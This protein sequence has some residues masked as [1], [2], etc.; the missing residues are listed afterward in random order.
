LVGTKIMEHNPPWGTRKIKI[1]YVAN[2]DAFVKFLLLPQLKFLVKEGYNVHAIFSNNKWADDIEKEG[3][4][5]KIIRIKRKIT[6]LYDLITLYRLWSYFKKEKF[7]MV[8]TN[9]PKPGLL[10][11]LAARMAGVPIIMNTVHGLYFQNNSSYLKRRFFIFIEKIAAKCSDLV[12]FVNKEDMETALRERIC[13][14]KVI[15]Y[16]GGGI[17]VEKF[18]PDIFS[19]SFLA[20]KRGKLGIKPN[21]R[22]IGIVAR[23]VREKGYLD[24][25]RAFK[26]VL[27]TFP[28][29]TLLVIGPKEPEKTDAIKPEIVESYGIENSVV[30][31]GERADV[32][33][34]YPLM[35]VFVLPSYRE[36]LGVAILEAMAEKRP[37]VASNIRG[38][39]EEIE[40]GKNGILV[41]IKNPKKLAEAIVYLFNNPG[42]AKELGDSARIRV[43][44]YFKESLIFDRI[45]EAHQELFKRKGI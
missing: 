4:K 32:D 6:P 8:H 25:F 3:I 40:N 23:L 18:N 15:K 33:Q 22:V 38:C 2:A 19:Q 17:D 28:E 20:G 41:P 27:K 24:L 30:F 37:V 16:L 39:R 7:D 1:C 10:G 36:G 44:R 31:L 12:F 26:A 9:N 34:I 14:K 35:D 43:Q 13:S 5:V 29:T 11:Q 45:K 42:K 21:Y